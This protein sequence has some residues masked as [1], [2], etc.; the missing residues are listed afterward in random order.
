MVPQRPAEP[1]DW[2]AHVRRPRPRPPQ[3]RRACGAGRL[4]DSRRCRAAIGR[5]RQSITC[6]AHSRRLQRGQRSR[7]LRRH[8]RNGFKSADVA[9]T[10]NGPRPPTGAAVLPRAAPTDAPRYR[11]PGGCNPQQCRLASCAAACRLEPRIFGPVFCQPIEII[12]LS[13]VHHRAGALLIAM[14]EGMKQALGTHDIG[15]QCRIAAAWR[16]GIVDRSNCQC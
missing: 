14:S 7:V 13:V 12:D 3:G 10:G 11:L 8:R 9:A 15:I 2:A 4:H 16:C 5:P 6:H 1:Y